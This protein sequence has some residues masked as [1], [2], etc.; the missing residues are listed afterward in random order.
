MLTSYHYLFSA[1]ANNHSTI[2]T[3]S[4]DAIQQG[5]NL[6]AVRVT[7]EITI[8]EDTV[9]EAFIRQYV[10]SSNFNDGTRVL[11]I[12]DVQ[13]KPAALAV[14]SYNVIDDWAIYKWLNIEKKAKTREMN[15]LIY[16][17]K[18]LQDPR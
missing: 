16:E 2:E 3:A 1:D 5:V 7:E 17:A 10:A 8:D 15:V 12:V 6:G 18:R 11:N 14:E 4:R 13:S 9:K